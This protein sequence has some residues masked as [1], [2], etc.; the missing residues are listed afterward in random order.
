MI[1]CPGLIVAFLTQSYDPAAKISDQAK[2]NSWWPDLADSLLQ[3]CTGYM[4]Y[5]TLYSYIYMR[6]D[7]ETG[8]VVLAD[9]DLL[10]IS[11]HMA[12]SIYMISA[13]IIGAGYMSAMICMLLG[14]I[15][16]PLHNLWFIGEEAMKL[17]CCNGPL[18]T[19]L[20]SANTIVLGVSYFS[21]RAIVA[22]PFFAG[23]TY[24]LLCTK[25]GRDNVPL[26]LNVFWN[27]LIWGVCFGSASWIEK[28]YHII[29]DY[30]GAGDGGAEL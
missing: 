17:D 4:I 14:E 19:S 2:P 11:H 1:L 28:C 7:S 27:F 21:I 24:V 15:T 16:N 6:W 25:R 9:G 18:A 22:P 3:F 30:F 13:R 8:G 12:T 20:H 29:V 10:F 5:D 26:P 23:V